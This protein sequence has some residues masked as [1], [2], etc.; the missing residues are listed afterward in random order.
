[1]RFNLS[2]CAA[3]LSALL[4]FV[5]AG[6]PDAAAQVRVRGT[7]TDAETGEPLPRANVHVEGTYRGTVTNEEGHYAL[8]VDSLP[9][10]LLVQYIGY[11]SERVRLP[12]G[13][14]G[15]RD[16]ALAPSSVEL[17]EVVVTGDA[18]PGRSIMRRV[19][20]QKQTWWDSLRT[21]QV[22]AFSRYTLANDSAI[23]S[24]YETQT[25][26]F[27]DREHGTREVLQSKRRTRNVS[28]L[29]GTPPA[30]ASVRNL[31]RDNVEVLGASLIGVTHPDALDHYSFTLDSVRVRDDQR[32]FDIR[33]EPQGELKSAF[34]GRVSVLDSAYAMI[35][36]R[37]RPAPS[38]RLPR[39]VSNRTLQYE[40]RFAN[41]GGP[42][43]LP[44][45]YRT[46]QTYKVEFSALL[47]FPRIN[48]EHTARFGE[49]RINVPLPDSLYRR[50]AE[51]LVEPADVAWEEPPGDSLRVD[52]L[53][54]AGPYVPPSEEQQR[55]YA[56]ID[57]SDTLIDAFEPG[58]LLGSLLELQALDDGVGIGTE[59]DRASSS[60]QSGSG[61]A[62]SAV[63]VSV[64]TPTFWYNRVE[65]THLGGKASVDLGSAL[66]LRGRG[67]HS[68]NVDGPER[69]SYGARGTLALP[70]RTVEELFLSYRYGVDPRYESDARLFPPLTRGV[71]SFW[72]LSGEPD[73]YDYFGNER[74]HVGTRGTV[75][76]TAVE[77]ELAYR[78]ERHF[79]VSDQ[80]SFNV[81]GRDVQQ[82]PNPP[83]DPGILRSVA[84][85]V[86]WGDDLGVLGILPVE[87]VVLNAEHSVGGL[88]SDFDFTRVDVAADARVET[89]FRRRLLPM[90]L[91]LRLDA[92]G[93]VGTLPLQRFGVVE[94]SPLPYTPFGSLRTL[95]D[96]PYQGSE[97][98][99]LFWEHNLR[100][101]PFEWLGLQALA[102][103]HIELILHGGHARTWIDDDQEQALRQRGP[104]FR[105]A[106]EV[107]HE[108]GISVNGLLKNLLRLD[109][110]AR[111][112]E[113]AF[114]I[115][116]S[117]V[118]FI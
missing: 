64:P 56:E 16:V 108:V 118:R 39:V 21:Y 115:G 92:G 82:P 2:W 4:L 87:Q 91:D 52:S 53:R 74:L 35:E 31:Y 23:V 100:T 50:D 98:A 55:A 96:R 28:M 83:I 6:G 11:E 71:N 34:T 36:A 27:W 86:Q 101:I 66:T 88:G 51:A 38:L 107:H 33:V 77:A 70:S 73:F 19:I 57:S 15:R 18:K 40:Q 12:E 29:E 46:E 47:T 94:A 112:N 111:L 20:E 48:A 14:D 62:L 105:T 41:V 72:T 49:Y 106:D 113:Q 10:T 90:T 65:G 79:S 68:F 3:F 5:A 24:I 37:L 78:N 30:S 116:V 17:D 114:S 42:Y 1:M 61:G 99:A 102:D 8:A 43:W 69:W 76:G 63:D 97:H 93:S 45:D 9:A 54:R 22:D 13:T 89:F 58:G 26:T 25:R 110:T 109:F 44:V 67:G 59:E 75:P 80:T 60:A 7:V 117:L 85:E 103:R 95:D 84:L 81:F 32:V 104:F